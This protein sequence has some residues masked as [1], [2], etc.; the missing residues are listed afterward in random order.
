MLDLLTVRPVSEHEVEDAVQTAAV[1]PFRLET[2]LPLRAHLFTTEPGQHVFVVVL[3]H[4][5]GDGWSVGPLAADLAAAYAARLHD[6]APRWSA[7]PVQYA[8]YTLWQQNVLGDENDTGSVISGQVDYWRE[9]LA[10]LPEELSLPT[11]RPRPVES[12]Y[13]GGWV[14]LTI[15]AE[16][17]ARLTTLAAAHGVSMFMLT[18][19]ALALLLSKL[20]AGTDIPI[21]SPIAG[22]TDQ[23]LDDLI[24]FFVNTL[25][26]RTDLSGDPTFAELLGRVRETNLDAHAHQ[27]VPF[28]R[29]VEILNPERS[30][31]RHPL[32]QVMLVFQNATTASLDLSGLEVGGYSTGTGTTK[33]DLTW[34][35]NELYSTDGRPGG[36]SGIV[37]Y[38]TDLYDATTITTLITRF[39]QLL[40]DLARTPDQTLATLSILTQS[41]RELLESWNDTAVDVP[42]GTV[43]EVFERQAGITPDAVAVISGEEQISYAE[44]EARANRLAHL[45]IE[46]GVGPERVVAL[47]MPRGI[48]MI[49]AV[50]GV[51]KAGGAYLPVDPTYPAERRQYMLD[52]AQPVIVL[53]A[54]P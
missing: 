9:Q 3:H 26:L 11:D 54:L 42:V 28:E 25:V 53:D 35:L 27:D 13:K 23:A 37:E 14:D 16:L 48:D 20:G 36:I 2:D 45:L 8:D 50:L 21:G 34:G 31:A 38:S 18:Q 33:F 6:Q 46:Q 22:R 19:T 10:E 24:G 47:S 43:G 29:L 49:T 51:L 40:D 39:V 7:L 32:F 52:D 44:L 12:S 30:L 4:I 5:A 41:E 1:A 15:D 17:H